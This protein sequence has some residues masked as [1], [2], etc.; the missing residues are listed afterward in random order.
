M[1]TV[2]SMLTMAALHKVTAAEWNSQIRDLGI[3]LLNPPAAE[4]YQT[5]A[6]SP[7]NATVTL[8]TF[9]SAQINNDGAWSGGAPTAWTCQ[10]AGTYRVTGAIS[11]AANSTGVRGV[12]PQLNGTALFTAYFPPPSAGT[13]TVVIPA[14]S[15]HFNVGDILRIGA[16][17]TSGGAL[18]LATGQQ[19][20]F[21]NVRWESNQ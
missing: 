12:Q 11:Y 3:F 6:Q 14:W 2:P 4:I 8:V 15:Q 18:A 7:A 21:L 16:Y 10:T 5:A 17:Q 13:A 1:A 20:T 19:M 9:D